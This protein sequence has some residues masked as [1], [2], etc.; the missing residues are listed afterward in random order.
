[1]HSRVADAPASAVPARPTAA[2]AELRLIAE[3]QP[4]GDQP[5]AI[6]ELSADVARGARFQ[7]LLGVT[8]SGKTFTMGNVIARTKK[9]TLVI[10]HNKTL[11]AQLYGEFRELFPENAV[12]FFVSYYDYYQPEAYLPATDTYIEK[13]TII[14]D[15]IER[16]RHSATHS[17]RTREDVIVV[18]S[19]SCIYGLGAARS[20]LAM[21]VTLHKGEEFGRDRLL[22]KLVD[23]HYRRS[24][25]DLHRGAFRA[26][27][28][29]VDIFPIYEED[30]A[31]RVEFFGDAVE[32][33]SE[34]DPLSGG[35]LW[36]VPKVTIYPGSHFVTEA[37]QRIDAI[38][39]IR[40][41]LAGRLAELRA[42][43]KLIEAQRLE[44]RTR[45]DLEALEEFG[46]CHGIE[47]Y[48]RHL[49][50]R[51]V[52]EPPPCLLDYFPEDFLIFVDESHQTIPQIA[53]MYRGDRSRK[54]TLVEYGFRLPSALDNRPLRFEE[55]EDRIRHAIFVSA[56]PGEY[57]RDKSKGRIVEQI[58]RPTGLLDPEVEVRPADNEVD[59]LLSEVR[60]HANRKER[61]LVTC[62][63]KRMAEDLADYYLEAGVKCRY[64]HSDIDTFERV[65]IVRDLRLGAFDAL[66]GI[67][68]L[69]EGL[70]IPEC[71]LVGILDADKEGFLRSHVSLIQTIGRA[72]RHLHGK[73]I[74][75]A[76]GITGSMRIALDETNRRRRIQARHNA[77]HGITPETV[78]RNIL[79]LSAQPFD[80]AAHVLPLRPE[81]K[82]ELLNKNDIERLMKEYA[83]RM[84]RAAE[85]LEFE[86]AAAWRDRLQLLKEMELGLTLPSRALLEPEAPLKRRTHG[87]HKAR[88]KN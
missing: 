8:G 12:E 55:F 83:G 32:R 69:R 76:N 51:A 31:I 35:R 84:Q 85:A 59:D 21:A 30:R 88:R 70:D 66:V 71:S 5:K 26:H 53:G 27:G 68:L 41:E 62:L 45:L 24:D 10:A 34:F 11:A 14:N 15:E 9:P 77:E 72:A 6:E 7:T 44:T 13:E 56:T 37:E 33:L 80:G 17:L 48:S 19:V 86:Q 74:L 67:N 29:V 61:V 87:R 36:E 2:M 78:H 54:E 58:I 82:A 49:G 22:R 81:D 57:E 1:M 3:I 42:A 46:Y 75:Y 39:A 4:K 20:Y 28:E 16:L 79:D 50:G 38:R 43:G 47:N 60:M 64:L 18:A 25:A 40:A 65:R 23:A 52:G 73:A 63:T